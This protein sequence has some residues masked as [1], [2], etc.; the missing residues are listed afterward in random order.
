MRSTYPRISTL[1]LPLL[2]SDHPF[3]GAASDS[4]DLQHV[5]D[6]KFTVPSHEGSLTIQ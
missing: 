5:G 2:L 1:L 4:I 6:G 3:S